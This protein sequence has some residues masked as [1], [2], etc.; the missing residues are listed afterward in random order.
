MDQNNAPLGQEVE[1]EI[2]QNTETPTESTNQESFSM[3]SLLE[4]QGLNLDF[5]TP[6]EIREGII[7]TIREN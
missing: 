2:P 3:E 1:P 4:E 5:P 6:G 7:A